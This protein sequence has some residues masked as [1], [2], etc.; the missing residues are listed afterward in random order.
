MKIVILATIFLAGSLFGSLLLYIINNIINKKELKTE[1]K[2]YSIKNNKVKASIVIILNGIGWLSA[3]A[4]SG[5]NVRTVQIVLVISICL[6]LSIIDI[7]IRKI[8][9]EIILF[10]FIST[11]IF[12]LT[13]G[14]VHTVLSHFIGFIVGLIIF[15]IPFLFKTR[16]GGGD[17]KYAA[18]MGF[19]LGY[20]DVIKAILIMSSAIFV[21]LIY[22]LFSKKGGLKTQLAMGSFISIGFVT[23]LIISNIK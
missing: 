6:V 15:I 22:L 9:N 1:M 3:V 19:C 7:E 11:T 20:P 8:P 16:A 23:T 17:V 13:G 18:A 21:W 2:S 4:I 5:F 10:L 14:S 12:I